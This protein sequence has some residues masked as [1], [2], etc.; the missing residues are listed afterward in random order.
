MSDFVEATGG[1]AIAYTELQATSKSVV[2]NYFHGADSGLN[3]VNY[4]N[5]QT[6]PS[7]ASQTMLGI[8]QPTGNVD[9]GQKCTIN[10]DPLGTYLCKAA[11][12]YEISEV[13]LLDT[14]IF[15]EHGRIRYCHNH[16]LALF[17]DLTFSINSI[18]TNVLNLDYLNYYRSNRLSPGERENFDNMTCNTAAHVMGSKKLKKVDAIFPAPF[19]FAK[20]YGISLQISLLKICKNEIKFNIADWSNVIVFENAITGERIVPVVGR[21]IDAVPRLTKL[22]LMGEYALIETGALAQ[23]VK[24]RRLTVEH[25]TTINPEN[26]NP[27]NSGNSSYQVCFN[28]LQKAVVGAIRNTTFNNEPANYSCGSPVPKDTYT[29]YLSEYGTKSP[30]NAMTISYGTQTKVTASRKYFERLLPFWHCR[31]QPEMNS[32]FLV[33]NYALNIDDLKPTGGCSLS[34][35]NRVL[36]KIEPSQAAKTAAIGGGTLE[37][38]IKEPQK[39]NFVCF[40]ISLAIMV[41]GPSSCVAP[42]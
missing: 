21:D 32:H 7:I 4:F 18:S 22:R 31:H 9:F 3:P 36:I 37:S 10:I 41:T 28:Y 30:V 6:F 25:I 42:S 38:G 29:D 5:M 24:D 1:P 13:N 23:T 34:I 39:F 20:D 11:L 33:Q 2:S 27:A 35:L 16:C 26:F 19:Y 15:K 40:A 8:S 12:A 17:Q 14:N